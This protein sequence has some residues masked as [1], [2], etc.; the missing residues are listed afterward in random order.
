MP[1]ISKRFVKHPRKVH[2]CAECH[3]KIEGPHWVLFGMAE[4]GDK[5]YQIRVH[6]LDAKC[7]K[8]N[9]TG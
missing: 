5:P 1:T 8:E 6:T 7:L 4:P 2:Y 9:S 3:K